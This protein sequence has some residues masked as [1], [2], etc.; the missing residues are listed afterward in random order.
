MRVGTFV[1]IK[2]FSIWTYGIFLIDNAYYDFE[3]IIGCSAYQVLAN[4][5]IF[6]N[7]RLIGLVL[8]CW[9]WLQ[10]WNSGLAGYDK[11]HFRVKFLVFKLGLIR[12][13]RP[14]LPWTVHQNSFLYMK[15]GNIENMREPLEPRSDLKNCSNR[16]LVQL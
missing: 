13:V 1:V 2:N 8:P 3:K 16:K 6:V 11:I 14:N 9:T 15:T 7:I 10:I 5:K 12:T 4:T